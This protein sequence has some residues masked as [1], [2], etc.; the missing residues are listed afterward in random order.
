MERYI[1][2][3]TFPFHPAKSFVLRLLQWLDLYYIST[4]QYSCVQC[5][6]FLMTHLMDGPSVRAGEFGFSLRHLAYY[7][8]S[9]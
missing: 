6:V 9:T 1:L 8:L 4:V 5:P 3:T 7:S 2:L